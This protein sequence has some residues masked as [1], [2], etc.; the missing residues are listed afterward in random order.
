MERGLVTLIGMSIAYLA[1][2]LGMGFAW[3]AWRR[4]GRG[5][6]AGRPMTPDEPIPAQPPIE[7]P[8]W[9]I[10][11]PALLF[12]A[13]RC[14]RRTCFTVASRE[15]GAAMSRSP[16]AGARRG[17]RTCCLF[18]AGGIAAARRRTD[19][20]RHVDPF[21]GTG[22]HGHT[23]PGATLPFGM[24]QLS[25]DTRLE[26]WDGCSGYHFTDDVVYGF[27]HTHLSGTGISDYGDILFMPVTGKAAAGRGYGLDPRISGTPRAST[28]EASEPSPAGMRSPCRTTG[29]RS[30]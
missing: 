20:A 7:G 26:G 9:T 4:Q 29:S 18:A 8:L 27:S 28:S 13:S 1:S 24:V 11:V 30:S 6:E 2:F 12:A 14:W 3:W 23:Y 5:R 17:S 19:P 16:T 10:V 22:G 25:P 15:D 21:I